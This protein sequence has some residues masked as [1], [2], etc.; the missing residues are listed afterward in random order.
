MDQVAQI[1]VTEPAGC[2]CLASLLGGKTTTTSEY[3]CLIFR[4]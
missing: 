1:S 2:G 3:N 4:R